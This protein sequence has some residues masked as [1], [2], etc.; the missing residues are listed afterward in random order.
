MSLIV[1]PADIDAIAGIFESAVKA[2][3]DLQRASLATGACA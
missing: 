3:E 1:T 2:A